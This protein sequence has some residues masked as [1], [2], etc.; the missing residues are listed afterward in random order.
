M[1]YRRPSSWV[2][3]PY[4]QAPQLQTSGRKEPSPRFP[5][6]QEA[7]HTERDAKANLPFAFLLLGRA[8]SGGD[9]LLAIR[10]GGMFLS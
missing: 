6:L 2:E 3:F 10:L 9:L 1:S 4:F 7:T 5:G 8:S